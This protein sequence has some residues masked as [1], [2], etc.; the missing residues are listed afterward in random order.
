[1]IRHKAKKDLEEYAGLLCPKQREE[2]F[3]VRRFPN[4]AVICGNYAG[5]K[6]LQSWR[7]T[8]VTSVSVI[9]QLSAKPNK[10]IRRL[11]AT[12]YATLIESGGNSP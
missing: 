5:A 9:G 1:M 11:R 4:A 12:G 2:L 3:N 10:P 6:G 8:A 7:T